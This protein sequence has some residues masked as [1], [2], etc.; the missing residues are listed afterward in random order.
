LGRPSG[1]IDI[2][3]LG[4]PATMDNAMPVCYDPS[5]HWWKNRGLGQG[6]RLDDVNGVPTVSLAVS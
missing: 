4:N 5:D 1:E 2:G 3:G 6:A